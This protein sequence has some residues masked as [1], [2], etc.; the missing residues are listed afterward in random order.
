VLFV[1]SFYAGGM[2]TER[3]LRT[4]EVASRLGVSRQHV[5]DLCKQGKLP[6]VMVG[7]H[8]RVPERAVTAR[9]SPARDRRLDGH[10]QSL[11]LHAAVVAKL[12]SDPERVLAIARRN[13]QRDVA[14]GTEHELPYAREWESLIA[15]GI[16]AVI[17]AMLDPSDHGVTLRS[18]TPFTGVL[19]AEEVRAIKRIYRKAWVRA[20]VS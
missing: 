3:L 1:V 2:S 20:G 5:V 14:S 6:H 12:I 18:S 9:L 10:R 7:V 17:E 4:G 8:R 19:D 13:L 16:P 15:E 11:A